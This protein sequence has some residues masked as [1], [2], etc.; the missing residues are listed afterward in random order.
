MSFENFNGSIYI[1]YNRNDTGGID[2]QQIS[3]EWT[4]VQ[5]IGC[6]MLSQIP[7]Q[8][9]RVLLK[10]E[11]N[12]N[13][14]EV[15]DNDA[16]GVNDFKVS[17]TH[18]LIW[19]HPS[20]VGK[21]FKATFGG[22]GV[23][24]ISGSRVISGLDSNGRPIVQ[25]DIIAVV[26]D[27]NNRIK[28]EFQGMKDQ[29][30]GMKDDYQLS[31]KDNYQNTVKDDYTKLKDNYQTNIVDNYKTTV[32]DDYD[33]L[34]Q[35]YQTDIVNKYNTEVK[36]DYKTNIKD[37]YITDVK[38]PW[39]DEL[40]PELE[41]AIENY[42]VSNNPNWITQ[43]H[44]TKIITAD[45]TNTF[46]IDLSSFNPV[47]DQINKFAYQS[48]G[49]EGA[50][51]LIEGEHWIR[52]GATITL[53]KDL[54]FMTGDKVFVNVYRGIAVTPIAGTNGGDLQN[55]SVIESKLSQDVQDKLNTVYYENTL[56][57][58]AT[59][60][61]TT[62]FTIAD[63]TFNPVTDKLKIYQDNMLIRKDDNYTLTGM[64]VTLAEALNIGDKIYYEIGKN[65]VSSISNYMA[66]GGLIREESVSKK[67]LTKDLQNELASTSEQLAD[68]INNDVYIHI[69]NF[70][71]T[72]TKINTSNTF[73]NAIL[74][75][76]GSNKILLLDG[77][78][79]ELNFNPLFINIKGIKGVKGKTII[80]I[81][82]LEFQ[83]FKIENSNSFIVEGLTISTVTANTR[84]FGAGIVITR[85]ND[86]EIKNNKVV[87]FSAQGIL[88]ETCNNGKVYNNIVKETTAD[89]I[90]CHR[91]CK[92][93]WVYENTIENVGDDGIASFTYT[94]DKAE[95]NTN[96]NENIFIYK[97]KI[98]STGN[99]ILNYGAKGISVGG[100][101]V[102]EIDGNI[103]ENTFNGGISVMVDKASYEVQ[104]CSDVSIT[105]NTI[106][107]NKETTLISPITIMN[108]VDGQI[109]KN[110]YVENNTVNKCHLGGVFITTENVSK[111]LVD[112]IS[113]KNNN[114]LND[115][116]ETYGKFPVFRIKRATNIIISNNKCIN[117]LGNVLR[118][119]SD[120]LTDNLIFED[121]TIM[122]CNRS[123][124]IVPCIE[125]F[126]SN[127][128][129]KNNYIIDDNDNY[130]IYLSLK[131]DG[132]TI[133]N[134]EVKNKK[135]IINYLN[136]ATKRV[137]GTNN[138]ILDG[139]TYPT[140]GSWKKGD[141]THNTSAYTGT[142][143]GWICITGGNPGTWENFG[144]VGMR[145]TE[146][147]SLLTPNFIGEMIR[148]WDTKDA[149]IALGLTSA[150][151]K[152]IT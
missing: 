51:E 4:V 37:A 28:P 31:V 98:M 57:F 21:S 66:D 113:I 119:E 59:V 14:R 77:R 102:V 123:K 27:Y 103:I 10:N 143:A 19:F 24:Y 60:N 76:N 87:N 45:D 121:N 130:A 54:V 62:Q 142:P 150:D 2:V 89:G 48:A 41:R 40:K 132:T 114:F 125:L 58:V 91:G 1:N 44:W 147:P 117:M 135:F 38:N 136:F 39:F 46:K 131:S 120:G 23:Q 94:T 36:Q 93:I 83:Q 35:N 78:Q 112:N 63:S 12:V 107:C 22:C 8:K 18:G 16:I 74:K 106:S 101:K 79:Y 140:I 126:G 34:K 108:A 43:A 72:D 82:D 73:A 6:S 149:Y 99:T 25:S 26:K 53:L 141:I 5:E 80:I 137:V 3:N 49:Q 127:N 110:V 122:N 65:A 33:N 134:N 85:C 97:N 69:D 7:Y 29:F 90:H 118:T 152:I 20:Q 124:N 139:T 105:N 67:K 75:L 9:Q 151:W 88:L 138:S 68:I 61:N 71:K 128:I 148:K 15:F 84:K 55:K 52:T 109:I 47:G 116:G 70:G 86:F 42:H 92:N 144:Q 133:E 81:D 115:V 129:I 13:L 146:S 111:S 11:A 100:S 32:K 145:S 95:F 64:V 50:T 104:S 56:N 96:Q 30:Q 17:Y